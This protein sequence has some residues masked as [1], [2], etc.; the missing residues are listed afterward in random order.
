[1]A[2]F[3]LHAKLISRSK[4]QSV[5][6]AAAYRSGVRIEDKRTGLTFDYSRKK[7]VYS[8][9]ILLPENAPA[10]MGDPSLLWNAVEAVEKRKDAQLA[11]ELDIAL[12]VELNHEEKRE[13]LRGFVQ[14]ELVSQ[15]MVAEIA[16]HDFDSH[17]PHAHILLTTR[18]IEA[19]EFGKKERSWNNRDFLVKLR[20]SWQD[21]ANIALKI[22]N[23]DQQIDCRSLEAQRCDRLPQIHLGVAVAAM[24]G[25]NIA[26]ERGDTY[27][28][29]QLANEEIDGLQ[30]KIAALEKT[31]AI[32]EQPPSIESQR[33]REV[34]DIVLNVMEIA[35]KH[36][37]NTLVQSN[38]WLRL[39]GKRYNYQIS[40]DSRIVEIE[41]NDGRGMIVR[42]QGKKIES[43]LTG[44]D[45]ERFKQI[46]VNV[47]AMREQRG[48]E[49]EY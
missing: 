42:Q 39:Q 25:K 28:A 37:P 34:V 38:G 40:T 45:W 19:G 4:G 21:H 41:A 1:M 3:H 23:T 46:K 5:T 18:R 9:E 7:R 16:F 44:D 2:I 43:Q 29:I 20:Q 47:E 32:E 33:A 48:I 31:L 26:T 17:N 49:I 22:A 35:A 27:L 11:R 8:S 36:H 30:G 15:G 6:A 13:L 24:M 10:W 14:R 12:P